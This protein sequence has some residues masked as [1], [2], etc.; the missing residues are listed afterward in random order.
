ME[1]LCKKSLPPPK[2]RDFAN[3]VQKM[4]TSWGKDVQNTFNLPRHV[5][6]VGPGRE[7]GPALNLAVPFL[8]GN[9]V[10]M[11]RFT[12]RQSIKSIQPKIVI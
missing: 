7:T 10:E 3:A 2:L 12:K 4:S 8:I 9:D 1:K 11:C 5:V 6:C